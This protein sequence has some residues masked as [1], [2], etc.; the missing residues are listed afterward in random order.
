MFPKLKAR[1]KKITT[2]DNIIDLSVDVLL[3]VYDVLSSPILIIVRFSKFFFRKY[4]SKYLKATIK[5]F[6]HKVL[7]IK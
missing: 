5:W 2:T 1:L 3:L 7:R 6:V 4:L